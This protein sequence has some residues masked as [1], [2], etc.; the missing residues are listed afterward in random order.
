M[1]VSWYENLRTLEVIQSIQ[2]VFF[3]NMKDS[4]MPMLILLNK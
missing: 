4:T 2:R 1:M 3:I